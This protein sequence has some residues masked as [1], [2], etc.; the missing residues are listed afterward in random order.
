MSNRQQ[1]PHFTRDLETQVSRFGL[2]VAAGLNEHSRSLPHDVTERLRFAREQALSKA[3]MA[4]A[5]QQVIA[6]SSQVVRN[7]GT[8]ALNGLGGSD[9]NS[10]GWFKLASFMP[11]VMLVLGLLLIQ[12][13][14]WYEQVTAAAEI[15]TALLSD[16]L[17]PAAYGDPGFSEFLSDEQE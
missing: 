7:G 8:L 9:E 1:P 14:G 16:N 17:P 10:Q 13:S 15:D 3:Q 5:A 12:H 11:L 6:P 2:S 4:R